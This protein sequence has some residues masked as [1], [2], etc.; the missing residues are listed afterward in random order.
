MI[1]PNPNQ[2]GDLVA[3]V[4]QHA[5]MKQL[6]IEARLVRGYR[7]IVGSWAVLV[8]ELAL[9]D[10]AYLTMLAKIK[11]EKPYAWGRALQKADDG[12]WQE[13]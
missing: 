9:L 7:D 8:A 12:N 11:A 13:D 1:V 2:L 4:K 10:D 5:E 6:R 3:G